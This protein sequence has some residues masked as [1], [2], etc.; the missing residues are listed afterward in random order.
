MVAAEVIA[1]SPGAPTGQIAVGQRHVRS[2]LVCLIP[3]SCV[4]GLAGVEC[5]PT[6][7][8]LPRVNVITYAI[9]HLAVVVPGRVMSV[10]IAD[11]QG[12]PAGG[13]EAH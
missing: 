5:D 7:G 9:W 11:Y 12:V 10:N 4:G 2:R 1:C 6:V 3:V 13:K 8:Q